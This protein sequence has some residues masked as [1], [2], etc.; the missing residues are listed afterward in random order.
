MHGLRCRSGLWD[1]QIDS[2]QKDYFLGIVDSLWEEAWQCS[3]YSMHWQASC[4]QYVL[5][6]YQKG[7]AVSLPQGISEP[8]ALLLR[9]VRHYLGTAEGSRIL[10]EQKLCLPLNNTKPVSNIDR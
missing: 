6:R 7:L 5:A 10:E 4:P 1:A 8:I 3:L 9:T 2:H